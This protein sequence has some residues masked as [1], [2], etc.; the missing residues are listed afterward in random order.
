MGTLRPRGLPRS[1]DPELTGLASAP[2][3]GPRGPPR[4]LSCHGHSRLPSPRPAGSPQ[5]P[6]PLSRALPGCSGSHS[7]PG[8]SSHSAGAPGTASHTWRRQSAGVVGGCREGSVRPGATSQHTARK[9]RL[10]GGGPRW[11]DTS[12]DCSWS[13]DPTPS[14]MPGGAASSAGPRG[15]L[16]P[17]VGAGEV[18]GP[19][20]VAPSASGAHLYRPRVTGHTFRP[21]RPWR[22]RIHPPPGGWGPCQDPRQEATQGRDWGTQS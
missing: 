7:R 20:W 1:R 3:A 18:P 16:G 9:R 21:R 2:T 17:R 10:A 4:V 19:W 12:T 13:A 5:L 11:A 8:P 22:V 6:P 15:T 14:L